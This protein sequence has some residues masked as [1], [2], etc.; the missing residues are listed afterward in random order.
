MNLK[1]E[2]MSYNLSTCV[3]CP[4]QRTETKFPKKRNYNPEIAKG[5]I[6]TG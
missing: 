2:K 6:Q 5:G 4:G 1:E 3:Y